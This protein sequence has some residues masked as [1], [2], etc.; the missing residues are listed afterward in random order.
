SATLA[1]EPAFVSR[2]AEVQKAL[3]EWEQ[4]RFVRVIQEYSLSRVAALEQLEEWSAALAV[5]DEA[6]ITCP[7]SEEL[8]EA[9]ERVRCRVQEQQ[10][11]KKLASRVEAIEQQVAAQIWS[12]ALSLIAAAQKEFPGEPELQE[13]WKRAEEGRRRSE[14]HNVAAEVQQRLG[15]PEP[16]RVELIRRNGLES[17]GQDPDLLALQNEL[18]ADKK[19]TEER[20]SAQFLVGHGRFADAEPIL[21]RLA[22]PD[23]P[24][25]DSLL[26]MLREARTASQEHDFCRLGHEQALQ[27]IEQRSFEDAVALLSKLLSVFPNDEALKEDLEVARTGLESERLPAKIGLINVTLTELSN[28]DETQSCAVVIRPAWPLPTNLKAALIAGMSLATAATVMILVSHQS[29]ASRNSTPPST[30]VRSVGQRAR[31]AASPSP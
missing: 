29:T 12:Q 2:L 3:L 23:R 28:S 14:L 25:V 27:L 24:E 8:H 11:Q 16:E 10:R 31:L 4:R 5:L 15:G 21:L 19:Y 6:L 18:E 20:R 1:E 30:A 9:G 7:E 22:A 26:E 13:V 17:L